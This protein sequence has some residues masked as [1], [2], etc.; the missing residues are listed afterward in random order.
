MTQATSIDTDIGQRIRTS[1]YRGN[2]NGGTTESDL[3]A[4]WRRVA[5]VPHS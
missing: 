5:R 1:R 2:G 4:T 3:P